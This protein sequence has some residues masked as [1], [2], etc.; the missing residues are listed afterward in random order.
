MNKFN[1]KDY[2]RKSF[3]C[4]DRLIMET[5]MDYK[6]LISKGLEPIS[7]EPLYVEAIKITKKD[8]QFCYETNKPNKLSDVISSLDK[9]FC[10][11]KQ[12]CEWRFFDEANDA[13][14]KLYDMQLL[15]D[16]FYVL[17]LN[18]SNNKYGCNHLFKDRL[19]FINEIRRKNFIDT[20]DFRE[21]IKGYSSIYTK[22]RYSYGAS[23][24]DLYTKVIR[25]YFLP[26][27]IGRKYRYSNY[28]W[29]EIENVIY[30]YSNFHQLKFNKYENW[31]C[32]D[33]IVYPKDSDYSLES[34]LK[35]YFLDDISREQ[36]NQDFKDAN[37]KIPVYT[38]KRVTPNL[39]WKNIGGDYYYG[40]ETH[41]WFNYVD[42][43]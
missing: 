4:K 18:V 19:K 23:D 13:L 29:V 34:N 40:R 30:R 24:N 26:L 14:V 3:V 42:K 9:P 37:T 5:S 10:I 17:F 38:E 12:A 36:Y 2:Y 15:Y 31:A 21:I 16:E 32:I 25:L 7:Q 39:Y 20:Y 1:V 28:N 22:D 43:C 27:L 33:E 6:D 35:D 41:T 11:A 8:N